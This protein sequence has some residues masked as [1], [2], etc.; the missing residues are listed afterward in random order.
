[1]TRED[2]IRERVAK[3]TPGPW[4]AI[5]QAGKDEGAYTIATDRKFGCSFVEVWG[6]LSPQPGKQEANAILIA[7]APADLAYLLGENER[8]R[9]QI[10]D[11]AKAL[12]TN[13]EEE[14]TSRCI[15]RECEQCGGLYTEH[16][17]DCP[18]GNPE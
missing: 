9:R 8:L 10:D 3:A 14:C 15:E 18:N 11:T 16:D 7:N 1:M 2:E 17:G 12:A 5:K 4:V 13:P 6:D